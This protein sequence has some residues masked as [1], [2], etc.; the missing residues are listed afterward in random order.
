[1]RLIVHAPNV[2][3]GGGRALLLALLAAGARRGALRAILDARLGLPDED[4][5]HLVVHRTRPSVLGRLSAERVLVSLAGPSDIVLCFGNLPPLLRVHGRVVL[6]LQNR[7][8]LRARVVSG[9]GLA[10]RARI[11]LE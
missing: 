2:H 4:I 10:T 5:A 11:A 3:Q 9:F 1:M 6:F 8:F 7:Y